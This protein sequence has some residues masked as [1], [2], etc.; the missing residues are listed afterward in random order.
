MAEQIPG[1]KDDGTYNPASKLP[2]GQPSDHAVYP[3]KAFDAG[4]DPSNPASKEAAI[5]FAQ[6]MIGRPGIHYVI[7]GDQ[8]W[9]TDQGLHYYPY[10]GH[11]SHV[12]VS[13]S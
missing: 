8:I 12:H 2:N 11:T 3:A 9:S 5:R 4:F 1:W 13:E 7:L 6:A 10:G